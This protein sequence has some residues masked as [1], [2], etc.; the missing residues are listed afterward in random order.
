MSG[1]G[2]DTRSQ[3]DKFADLARELDADEDEAHFEDT[4]R[5]I[6]KT[7]PPAPTGPLDR[8]PG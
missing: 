6:A 2:S 8:E 7:T 3:V 1:P 4:V 5:K